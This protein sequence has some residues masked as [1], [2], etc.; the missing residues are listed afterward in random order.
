M[1]FQFPRPTAFLILLAAGVAL[2][3][4]SCGGSAPSS[5]VGPSSISM[6]TAAT[7]DGSTRVTT[8]SE[9]GSQPADELPPEPPPPPAPEPPPAPAPAPAPPPPPNPELTPGPFPAPPSRFPVV[10]TPTPENHDFLI[11]TVEM[12]PVPFSGVPVPVQSCEGL[13]HTWYY[14]NIIHSRTGNIF[15]VVERENYFDGFLSSR[16]GATVDL[17]G[18]QRVEIQTRWCSSYGRAHT[19]QHRF[20]IVGADGREFIFN[21]QLIQLLQN[22]NWVPPPP[23]ETAQS[24][25][26]LNNPQVWGD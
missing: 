2:V 20:R 18:Q 1:S 22:P 7:A 5:T 15:R 21:T 8:A 24:Y 23:A 25:R 19:S 17:P 3:N 4:A 12:N 6:S 10:W 14:K 16:S 26:L 9:G 11:L 13:G